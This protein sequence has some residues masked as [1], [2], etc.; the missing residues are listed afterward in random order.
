M[1]RVRLTLN[2][3]K[4]RLHS[5]GH[6][7]KVS[8]PFRFDITALFTGNFLSAVSNDNDSVHLLSKVKQKENV[9][10]LFDHMS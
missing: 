4:Q 10:Q 7:E 2:V 5:S 3:F 8:L 6:E 9:V 1:T